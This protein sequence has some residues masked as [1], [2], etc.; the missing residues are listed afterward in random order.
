MSTVATGHTA[1]LP[2]LVEWGCEAVE[3]CGCDT[4]GWERVRPL[5]REMGMPVGLHSPL[6]LDG[7]LHRFDITSTIAE[8]RA[9]ALDMV[10]RTLRAAQEAESAYVVVHF[11]SPFPRP[12]APLPV[13]DPSRREFVL[14]CGEW[15]AEAQCRAGVPVFVENLSY[16]PDFG[17]AADYREF[18]TVYPNL[19]MC[20]DVGHAHIS[21]KVR[22]VHEFTG[23]MAEV[24]ASAHLYNTRRAG[25][26]IGVHTC[27]LPELGPRDDWIDLPRL[28]GQLADQA[29]PEYLVFEYAHPVEGARAGYESTRWLREL[30]SGLSWR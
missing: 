30:I 16:H 4:A 5:V 23:A 29:T 26:G 17:S 24:I 12:T 28:L 22:D 1:D 3:L 7:P 19:R 21:P 27:P 14:G 10:D 13:P 20:L 6:P 25:Q 18:F 8:Q 2:A 11:P 9:V 15:L